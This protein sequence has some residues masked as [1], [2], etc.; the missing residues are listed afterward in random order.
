ML[1]LHALAAVEKRWQ[2]VRSGPAT[3]NHKQLV[4]LAGEVYRL[5]ISRFEENSGTPD[6]WAAFKAFNRVLK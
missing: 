3:L 2:A 6:N 5:F 1:R 4:A